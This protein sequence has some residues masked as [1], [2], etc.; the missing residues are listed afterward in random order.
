MPP[1]RRV[2]DDRGSIAPVVPLLALVVLLLAGLVIDGSRQLNARARAT[3][4]AEEAARA[5]AA[6]VN[7]EVEELELL[8]SDV[9]AERV[10]R[11]C[12][13]AAAAG[14]PIR[15]PGNCFQGLEDTKEAPVRRLV[16]V[17]RVET[18]IPAGL[19]GIAGVRE[20]AAA[21]EAKA[22]PYQGLDE[23]DVQ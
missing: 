12:L 5:G 2:G 18:A 14:A 8:P 11:Y 3:A 10:N 16:V 19:L 13:D 6:A 20:L 22:R 7:L 17:A 21:G 9:V 4:Y 15:N 23:T 1:R